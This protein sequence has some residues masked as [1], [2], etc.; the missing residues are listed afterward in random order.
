MKRFGRISL[1]VTLV[2][3][4]ASCDNAEM[5]AVHSTDFIPPTSIFGSDW[6]SSV[7]N[8]L[9]E[10]TYS[11]T[12]R[13][14]APG[15]SVA[16]AEIRVSTEYNMSVILSSAKATI[17]GT[18]VSG[19]I[20]FKSDG[21]SRYYAQVVCGRSENSDYIYSDVYECGFAVPEFISVDVHD[22]TW[23]GCTLKWTMNSRGY[24]LKEHGIIYSCN[25]SEMTLDKAKWKIKVNLGGSSTGNV[26]CTYRVDDID[27]AAV[28]AGKD[29]SKSPLYYIRPYAVTDAGVGYGAIK[30]F[31]AVQWPT[32]SGVKVSEITTSSAIL[33]YT[34]DNKPSFAITEKVMYGTTAATASSKIVTGHK[35]TGLQPG[36][37]YYCRYYLS[38][39]FG[40]NLWKTDA[41]EFT[42]LDN[43]PTPVAFQA[44][45]LGL[46]SGVKWANKNVGAAYPESNGNFFAWGEINPKNDYSW[47]TYK[48]NNSGTESYMLYKYVPV[49]ASVWNDDRSRLEY[50]DDAARAAL[51]GTWRMPTDAEEQ[52]LR[53][54]C[55]WTWTQKNG[56]NGYLVTG[57]NGNSIF[58]PAAGSHSGTTWYDAG[59]KG[60][61]WTSD[62]YPDNC[63]VAYEFYFYSNFIGWS[64]MDRYVG[65]PIRPVTN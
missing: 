34:V 36:A 39:E 31:N 5:L 45:D 40:E 9:V 42:T 27:N 17:D 62:V 21:A 48:W 64:F 60:A 19:K 16:F 35:M 23:F 65:L 20:K 28:A 61:Y 6:M 50:E 7:D 22:V 52:E 1:F 57:Q 29:K 26:N 56:V 33:E 51:G 38:N 37:T 49:P 3:L 63:K 8:G 12:L 14:G 15:V 24:D 59:T 10:L 47:T 46:P 44:V 55:T 43:D 41:I 18:S 13:G 32:F 4:A 58:L 25:Y 30:E 54:E 53:A 11:G 2:L